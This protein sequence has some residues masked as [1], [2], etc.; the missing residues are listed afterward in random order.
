MIHPFFNGNKAR[1]LWYLLEG[2]PNKIQRLVSWGGAQ[3]N[4]MYAL[5]FLARYR[6]WTFQYFTRRVDPRIKDHPAG[7][8]RYAL[9]NGMTLVEV[10]PQDYAETIS[11]LPGKYADE[12]TH[13]VPMGGQTLAAEKG[14]KRLAGELFLQT[15]Q[16]NFKASDTKIFL[17]S[18]TGT[19]AACLARQMPG[20]QIYT[21]GCVGNKEYLAEQIKQICPVPENLNL[22]ESPLKVPFGRPHPALYTC[23]RELLSAGIEFDLIYDTQ[24]WLWIKHNLQKLENSHV[25]FIHSGGV[26]GNESQ[27][28][29]YD[30]LTQGAR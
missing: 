4:A 3:S 5:S 23:Y 16:L 19:T 28:K 13:L 30:R 9:E 20:F 7:N 26:H 21:V 24:V 1:K 18:G 8:L 11:G 2:S 22:L 6:K 10:H 27:L 15:G 17:S 14:I 25:I 29:R 12:V